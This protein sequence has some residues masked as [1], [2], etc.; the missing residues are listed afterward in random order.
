MGIGGL[1]RLVL[2]EHGLHQRVHG[3][4]GASEPF[5]NDA[6]GLRVAGLAFELSQAIEQIGDELMF[7]R[8]HA[9][10]L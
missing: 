2:H 4:R 8:G 6:L 3:M 9:A 10:L 1:E 7:L 5:G